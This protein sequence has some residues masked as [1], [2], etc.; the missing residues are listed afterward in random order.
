LVV[1]LWCCIVS[2]AGCFC[3]RHLLPVAGC[4][5]VFAPVP[6]SSA[7]HGDSCVFVI[8]VAGQDLIFCLSLLLR[9]QVSSSLVF[10]TVRCLLV[11][12]LSAAGVQFFVR[13][14][15]FGFLR[16]RVLLLAESATAGSVTRA[17]S[18]PVSPACLFL[19]AR[20]ASSACSFQLAERPALFCASVSQLPSSAQD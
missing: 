16:H 10:S 6:V 9:D 19:R 5:I 17:S 8:P 13:P 18:A 4:G 20:G 11:S 2:R 7:F 3:Y 14:G 15:R 1:I 12:M